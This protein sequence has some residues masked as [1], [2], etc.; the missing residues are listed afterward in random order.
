MQAIK[1]ADVLIDVIKEEYRDDIAFVL[2]M[3]SNIYHDTHAKSDLDLLFAAKTERGNKLASAF[4]I[5]G[6]GFD[7]WCISWERLERIA[8]HDERITSIITEGKLI[9]YGNDED[10][11]KFQPA[12][13][14]SAG[15]ERRRKIPVQSRK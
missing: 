7:I 12:Q 4:I 2:I 9:Y 3:G 8:N 13:G 6:I 11:E 15:C 10:L 14:K 5:D 1:A